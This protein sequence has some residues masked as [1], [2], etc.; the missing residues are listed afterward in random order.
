MVD[1]A[2]RR[3]KRKKEIFGQGKKNSPPRKFPAP[4]SDSG[5]SEKKKIIMKVCR[6]L[7][8]DRN[9]KKIQVELDNS[10]DRKFYFTTIVSFLTAELFL[11]I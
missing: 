10:T 11:V 5:T 7:L 3:K 8:K 4:V 6:F 9:L 2:A 1:M